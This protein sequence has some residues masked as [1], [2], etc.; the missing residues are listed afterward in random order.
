MNNEL[1]RKRCLAEA[2]ISAVQNLRDNPQIDSHAF[3]IA[4]QNNEFLPEA[5][6]Y[7]NTGL[8]TCTCGAY[9]IDEVVTLFKSDPEAAQ[10]L[11]S[12]H[13]RMHRISPEDYLRIA[14]QTHAID[15]DR[16]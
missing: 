5:D 6:D 8:Q 7:L 16:R 13:L 9:E 12:D 3:R 14:R 2:I 15:R 10:Q 11:A 1:H 4:A